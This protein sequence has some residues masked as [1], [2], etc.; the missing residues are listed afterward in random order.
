[1]GPT[2]FS[3][4]L[5]GMVSNRVLTLHTGTLQISTANQRF[6]WSR[7]SSIRFGMCAEHRLSTGCSGAGTGPALV[8]AG[9]GGGG[10]WGCL[11]GRLLPPPGISLPRGSSD[12][13]QRPPPTARGTTSTR[14]LPFLHPSSVP[15]RDLGTCFNNPE[16]GLENESPPPRKCKPRPLP[17]RLV[18]YTQWGRGRPLLSPC[19]G[20]SV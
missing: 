20:P 7:G 11:W 5:W 8:G 16:A 10:E 1:M 12:A 6:C 15:R 2:L 14:I 13:P 3:T 17:W 9:G 4:L 18:C 19:P